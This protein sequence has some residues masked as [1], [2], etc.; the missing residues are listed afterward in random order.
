MLEVIFWNIGVLLFGGG[1][2]HLDQN[3][4]SSETSAQAWP[5]LWCSFPLEVKWRWSSP[6]AYFL[7]DPI[8]SCTMSLQTSPAVCLSP[9][10]V[11]ISREKVVI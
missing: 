3:G 8:M 6:L 1:E 7:Q 5:P 4:L 9:K 10:Q 11:E 2:G